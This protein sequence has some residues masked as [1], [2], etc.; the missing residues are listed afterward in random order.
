[1][2]GS[3]DPIE[4]RSATHPDPGTDLVIR[5]FSDPVGHLLCVA[6]PA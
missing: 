6:G 1:M 5:H 3:A 4:Q 2:S